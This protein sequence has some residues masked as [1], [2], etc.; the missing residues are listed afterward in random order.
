M[1]GTTVRLRSDSTLQYVFQGDL[2][3]DSAAGHYQVRG[4]KV[5]VLFDK[6]VRDTGKLYYRFDNMPLRTAT[7]KGA[8]VQYKLLL[9][10]GHHKLFPAY[11]ATGKKITSAR[12]YSRR[13]KYLLFGSHYY[14]RRYYYRRTG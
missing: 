10:C 2:L 3:Y 13:R 12:R 14:S 9:Y 5:Y 6:E 11:A 7:Y 1:F 4:N 8:P